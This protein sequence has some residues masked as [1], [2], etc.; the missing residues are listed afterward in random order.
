VA[1]GDRISLQINESIS[2]NAPS[3]FVTYATTL[4]CN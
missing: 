3:N 1:Q 4:V 2:D